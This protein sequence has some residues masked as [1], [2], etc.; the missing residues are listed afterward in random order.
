LV[1]AAGPEARCSSCRLEDKGLTAG[2]GRG[3][4]PCIAHPPRSDAVCAA[5]AG[6]VRRR[7]GWVRLAD[8]AGKR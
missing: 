3:G 6:L 2:G 4:C 8:L 5:V 7:L 1:S